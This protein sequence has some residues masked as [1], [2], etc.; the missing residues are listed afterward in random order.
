[1]KMPKMIESSGSRLSRRELIMLTA[2][3]VLVQLYFLFYQIG[4]PEFQRYAQAKQVND[5][6]KVSVAKLKADYDNIE[7]FR[8]ELEQALVAL[9]AKKMELPAYIAQ[10]ETLLL[11]DGLAAGAGLT[12]GVIDYD[13]L[14]IL[15]EGAYLSGIGGAARGGAKDAEEADPAEQAAGSTPQSSF[16][17]ADQRV[18]LSFTGSYEAMYAF[19]DSLEQSNRRVYAKSL[20]LSSDDEGRLSG[21]LALSFLSHVDVLSI[22]RFEMDLEAIN[23]KN[24]PF[25]PYAGYLST[26]GKEVIAPQPALRPDFTLYL[27]SYLDNAPKVIFSDSKTAAGQLPMDENRVANIKL[28]VSPS[29]GGFRYTATLGGSTLRSRAE[30]S[31]ENGEII[32]EVIAQD[33]RGARDLVGATLDVENNSDLPVR[34]VVSRDDAQNPRFQLGSVAGSV[35]LE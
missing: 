33:R 2:L 25:E 14:E 22:E 21:S 28:T 19:I 6:R 20:A 23:G 3:A 27:N 11:I 1:M 32:I 7:A 12:V 8:A 34:I 13:S 10:E 26:L 17:V 4:L 30:L 16:L 9:E 24:R 5:A 29:A 31:A 35:S 15:Q 18:S